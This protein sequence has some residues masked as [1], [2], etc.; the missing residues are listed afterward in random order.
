MS[1]FRYLDHMTDA[2]IEAYGDSLEKAF[3]YSAKGLVNTMFEIENVE[4]SIKKEI[5]AEGHDIESLLFD[6]L[7]K[8]M[9]VLLTENLILSEF[10]IKSIVQD[11]RNNHFEFDAVARGERID[12]NKHEYKVEIKAV[13][14]HEMEIRKTDGKFIV[15]FLLD[16]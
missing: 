2:I 16:L 3:E 5:H 13:T 6:W 12:M 10:Q 15:K 4:P 7:D 9:L 1:G 8:V 11:I 14:Y